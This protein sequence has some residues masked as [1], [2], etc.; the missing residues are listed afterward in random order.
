VEATKQLYRA[1]TV[2]P[3]RRASRLAPVFVPAPASRV[4]DVPR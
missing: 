1:I 3:A 2:R 4:S